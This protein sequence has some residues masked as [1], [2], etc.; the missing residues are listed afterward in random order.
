MAVLYVQQNKADVTV[1]HCQKAVIKDIAVYT[2]VLVL[3]HSFQGKPVVRIL[4][5]SFRWSMQ[6]GT[7]A[8]CQQLTPTCLPYEKAT[9]EAGT[10]ALQMTVASANILTTTSWETSQQDLAQLS[11]IPKFLIHRNHKIKH[12]VSW[13]WG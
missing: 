6:Q 2:L 8:S 1:Y 4:K 9:L 10:P 12:L 5:Q 7:K 11:S 13:V 3:D